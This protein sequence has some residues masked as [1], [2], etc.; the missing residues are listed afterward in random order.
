MAMQQKLKI[1]IETGLDS[2]S[3]F[4]PFQK[5]AAFAAV[6]TAARRAMTVENLYPDAEF[7]TGRVWLPASCNRPMLRRRVPLLANPRSLG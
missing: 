4:S 2:P 6:A 1:R 5:P 7:I 3:Q